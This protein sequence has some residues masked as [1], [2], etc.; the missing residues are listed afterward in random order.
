[1]I[2]ASAFL[3]Y[4]FFLELQCKDEGTDSHSDSKQPRFWVSK[5]PL[6]QWTPSYYDGRYSTIYSTYWRPDRSS[7]DHSSYTISRPPQE[8][9]PSIPA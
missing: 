4:R 6:K 7:Y 8:N 3:Y 1:M 5:S 2:M 9:A